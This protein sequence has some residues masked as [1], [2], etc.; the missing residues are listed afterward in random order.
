M[1][2]GLSDLA[3]KSGSAPRG[4]SW[5]RVGKCGR[6]RG[7]VCL[8]ILTESE[9]KTLDG[10]TI[11]A[12]TGRKRGGRNVRFPETVCLKNI[13]TWKKLFGG[14]KVLRGVTFVT[15]PSYLL[16]LFSEYDFEKVDLVVGD[17]LMD[18]Y[19]NKLE[20]EEV[21]ISKLYERVC[22][23]SLKLYGTKARIHTKLYMLI[24]DEKTRIINGSP[25]LS[26][27]AQGARQREYVWYFDIP[28]DDYSGFDFRDTIERDL[29]DH[30]EQSDI[31]KFMEDLQDLRKNSENDE[32]ED[33]RYWC[34][35]KNGDES[36]KAMRSVVKEVQEMAFKDED[37]TE[38]SYVID[39]PSTV[40]KKDRTWLSKNYGATIKNGQGTFSRKLVLNESS[41]L[42]F[43]LMNVDMSNGIVTIGMEGKKITLPNEYSKEEI[44]QG[45]QDIEDYI[46]LVDRAFCHHPDAVKMTMY[47]AIIFTMAAPF[48]NEWL[49]QKRLRVARTDKRG[50]RH[51]LIFG[52]GHNGKTTFGRLL[53]HL[54]C[55]KVIDPINGKKMDKKAWDNMFEVVSTAGT[56]YPAIIDDIKQRCFTTTLEGNIKS[57]FEND[58]RPEN[59]YPMMIFNTNY[60]KMEEWA[61]SRVRKLDFLVKFRDSESEQMVI[62]DIL[63]RQ[64]AVFPVFSRLFVEE[65]L[66]EPEFRNDELFIARSVMKKIYEIADRKVPDYF[67]HK[68]PEKY[69]NMDAIYCV[70][71]QRY[72]IFKESRVKG[73]VR[74]EF[75][76]Y[77]SLASFRS[78]LPVSVSSIKDGKV[79]II[80]NPDEYREF[81]KSGRKRKGGF[82]RK[83]ISGY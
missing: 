79:L 73:G 7:G 70:D 54:L 24:N 55:G 45:L 35:T 59:T 82:F 12:T 83:M 76:E 25:N 13:R 30:K 71:R 44:N 72:N 39:I 52:D 22:D 64:N 9:Q 26:Y 50:P 38:E 41:N 32:V 63:G 69:Y 37:E 67:P 74:L 56:P 40:K 4:C 49:K 43:P 18:G 77:G 20:G 57:Y 75:N 11:S 31:V 21:T 42:G 6:S 46:S 65:L 60:D 3:S 36:T 78:R 34:Q 15:S 61:K 19:R 29:N 81:M 51:L 16:T 68:P 62:N 58:W 53:N 80:Q 5:I 2:N 47:E 28:H 66:S 17:G 10:R 1:Q 8:T 14:F 23:N 48:A 33:F 27:T